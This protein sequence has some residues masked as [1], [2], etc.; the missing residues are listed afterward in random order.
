MASQPALWPDSNTAKLIDLVHRERHQFS[1][2]NVLKA[3][4]K[5]ASLLPF[6]PRTGQRYSPS[7]V[8]K[9][10]AYL[11]N[12][13]GEGKF[14]WDDIAREGRRCLTWKPTKGPQII[15]SP[16]SEVGDSIVLSNIGGETTQLIDKTSGQF[17]GPTPASQDIR[18]RENRPVANDPET[19][20]KVRTEALLEGQ[21]VQAALA[22][23]FGDCDWRYVRLPASSN[24]ILDTDIMKMMSRI[25]SKMNIAVASISDAVDFNNLACPQWDAIQVRYPETSILLHDILGLSEKGSLSHS[26]AMLGLGELSFTDIIKAL[27][28][29]AIH[30]W[31]FQSSFPTSLTSPDKS[32]AILE[33]ILDEKGTRCSTVTFF[34]K[35]P[36]IDLL[37]SQPLRT[38]TA[39]DKHLSRFTIP[40]SP[41]TAQEFFNGSHWASDQT[42]FCTT[43]YVR[44][45]RHGRFTHWRPEHRES[46]TH[47][48]TVAWQISRSF[49]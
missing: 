23:I 4:E 37:T 8:R 38:C 44:A 46:W 25:L 3:C 26:L 40:M 21:Q 2:E 49:C 34:I 20:E 15:N 31:V 17:D 42:R 48:G 16:D 28:G 19:K 13:K 7:E 5:I 11:K 27:I 33:R 30:N 35:L 45:T 43:T 9:K 12:A 29:R 24:T 6:D 41:G 47:V 1:N 39:K 10:L 36:L 18:S 22:K 32:V 14:S